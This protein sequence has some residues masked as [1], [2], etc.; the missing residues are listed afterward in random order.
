VDTSEIKAKD[1]AN[2]FQLV[3]SNLENLK[4]SASSLLTQTDITEM[5]RDFFSITEAFYPFLKSSNY[6]GKTRYILNCDMAFGENS[7][8]TWIDT[9]S[10][11]D[12]FENPYLGKNHPEYKS[13]MLHCG[14]VKDSIFRGVSIK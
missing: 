5:R 3:V 7:S 11:M 6:E 4:S 9:T 10:V 2:V 13:T 14:D 1:T 12:K 8:A